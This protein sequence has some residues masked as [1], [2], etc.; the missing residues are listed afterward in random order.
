MRDESMQK[1]KIPSGS[2]SPKKNTKKSKQ[3]SHGITYLLIILCILLL[4]IV[5]SITVFFHIEE[6]TV[7]GST[8]YQAEE[9]IEAHQRSDQQVLDGQQRV[10]AHDDDDHD[11]KYDAD[12]NGHHRAQQRKAFFQRLLGH[13][14]LFELI[15]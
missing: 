2:I 13:P 12:G 10:V 4:G 15:F 5:L 7:I 9:I 6:I 14:P 11:G 1:Y 3:K 8:V